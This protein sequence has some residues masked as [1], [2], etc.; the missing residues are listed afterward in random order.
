[1]SLLSPPLE[2]FWAVVQK[3]TV[4]E[5]SRT[6]GLTQTGVTQ[7]IRSIEKM[8]NTTLFIRSRKGMKL[9]AE[10][11]SLLQYVKNSLDYEGMTLSKIQGTNIDSIIEIGISG[12]SSILRSRVIPQLSPALLKYKNLRFRFDLS[13]VDSNSD[14]L[15]TGF[16]DLAI[17]EHHDVSKEMDSR[18]IKP[19]RYKLYVATSWKRR[20]FSDIITKESI[21][22]F[23]SKDMMTLNYLEKYKHKSKARTDRHFA[24]NTDALTSMITAGV[25]YSVL[26]EEFAR[27]YIKKGEIFD[28]SPFQF[29]D[30]KIALAWYHRPHMPDYFR[31]ITKA[32]Q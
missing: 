11:E 4:Q 12:P 1:M 31:S 30:F 15:K 2:A 25:G 10:G 5:A 21:I 20:T 19:E 27:P 8:L 22:D 9:T 14:K 23:N 16:C 7:R 17:L 18:I 29:F 32:I 6:I 24:N 28:I 3:G 26:S 13:D